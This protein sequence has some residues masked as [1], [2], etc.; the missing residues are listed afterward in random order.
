M[1]VFS[2]FSRVALLLAVLLAYFG[3]SGL[4]PQ[5]LATN[6]YA[7]S[8][9]FTEALPFTETL[10]AADSSSPSPEMKLPTEQEIGAAK[11]DADRNVERIRSTTKEASVLSP[12]LIHEAQL[13]GQLSML[14]GQ[15]LNALQQIDELSEKTASA[16]NEVAS[17]ATEIDSKNGTNLFLAYDAIDSL[18]RAELDRASTLEQEANQNTKL[19]EELKDG[20][21]AAEKSRR[22]LKDSLPSKSDDSSTG[23]ST[24]EYAVAVLESQVAYQRVVLRE[25]LIKNGRSLSK[26]AQRKADLFKVRLAPR[27]VGLR[28]SETELQ[29]KQSEI[30]S[31][32]EELKKNRNKLE[33]S[34]AK[35]NDESYGPRAGNKSMPKVSTTEANNAID[36][37]TDSYQRGIQVLSAKLHGLELQSVLWSELHKLIN[38]TATVEEQTLWRKDLKR[39]TDLIDFEERRYN[40]S[41]AERIKDYATT[42]TKL[43]AAPPED[44]RWLQMQQAALERETK[45]LGDALSTIE[46]F[47]GIAAKVSNELESQHSTEH[48]L[49]SINISVL[50]TLSSIWG[51]EVTAV[52]DSPITIGKICLALGLL[53]IGFWL[54]RRISRKIGNHLLP[55]LRFNRGAISAIESIS[56]YILVVIFALI[57]LRIVHIPLTVFTILGGALAIG[58]GFGSQNIMNNFIS[59]LIILAEQPIRVGDI[60]EFDGNRGLVKRIGARS[61]EITTPENFDAIVPNSTLLQSSIINWTLSNNHVRRG[62]TVGVA[63]GSP[64]KLVS[65][66]L[67]KAAIEHHRVLSNPEPEVLFKNFGDNALEFELRFWVS[68]RQMNEAL[69]LESDMRFLIDRMFRENALVIAYPQRDIHLDTSSPLEVR[70]V[71]TELET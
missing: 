62:V 9:P 41:L 19:L 13:W 29:I 20:Y 27:R 56:F 65:E 26:L 37:M 28:F 52:D 24:Q 25:L 22:A 5:L 35:L 15:Q 32:I 6:G 48:L 49:R 42:G 31:R 57:A 34:L 18:R 3:P 63:Y 43:D 10:K 44:K 4:I 30:A 50:S 47:R 40:K 21:T 7:Q 60:I 36:A 68:V 64:V 61:T 38:G 33:D 54:S 55:R 23:T 58:V 1:L 67:R 59:G 12:S 16:P 53:V 17:A 8:L 14:Y 46:T 45:I 2:R 69:I 70:I 11:E 51:Y 39:E 66:I 71:S